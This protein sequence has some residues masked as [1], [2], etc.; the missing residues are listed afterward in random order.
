VRLKYEAGMVLASFVAML[1]LGLWASNIVPEVVLRG[2]PAWSVHF[3]TKVGGI[4]AVLLFTGLGGGL[5]IAIRVLIDL[6]RL[7]TVVPATAL[8]LAATQILTCVGF[9]LTVWYG[10]SYLFQF[11]K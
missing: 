9:A 5:G 4:G 7:G 11:A 2:A 6:A 8:G 1:A 3:S 10:L